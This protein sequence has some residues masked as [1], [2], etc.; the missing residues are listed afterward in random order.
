MKNKVILIFFLSIIPAIPAFTME[1]FFGQPFISKPP[2]NPIQVEKETLP[3]SPIPIGGIIPFAGVTTPEGW[4]MCDG[5]IVSSSEYKELY[6]VIGRTYTPVNHHPPLSQSLFCVPDMTGRIPVG[7]DNGSR[8]ITSNNILG[9]SGGEET[10]QLTISEMPNHKHTMEGCSTAANPGCNTSFDT[11]PSL[12]VIRDTSS[13]GGNQPHNNMQ[14][15][16]VLNY[17]IK[18]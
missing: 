9:A 4:L 16:L 11:N 18:H 7:I 3:I 1:Q 2:S 8:R 6:K 12:S 5:Q 13:T 14:P 10:H 15:Y 17:I